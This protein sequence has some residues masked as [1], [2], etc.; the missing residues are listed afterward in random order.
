MQTLTRNAMVRRLAFAL[1]GQMLIS[2]AARAQNAPSQADAGASAWDIALGGGVA[3][4]PSYEGSD[5]YRVVPAPLVSVNWTWA[6]T[7]SLGSN[8]LNVYWHEDG[9]RL[10]TGLAYDSGRKD[11]AGNGIFRDGDDRLE[12]LGDIG[13]AAGVRIFS[14]YS[15]RGVTFS[16]AVTRFT[17]GNNGGL[18]VDAGVSA[19]YVLTERATITLRAGASWEDRTR[20]QQFFGVTPT[21]ALNSMF[22]Q[23]TAHAGVKDVA[24]GI[25]F[26]YRFSQHL[27]LVAGAGAKKLCGDAARSPITFAATGGTGEIML[28]YHF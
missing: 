20:M 27:F 3:V 11:S 25:T 23:F 24:A 9:F 6:D 18:Q 10:G 14:A 7:V 26:R 16:E 21:Q 2:L 4:K 12:G 17:G 5:R 28:G 8:G 15:L 19:P 13:A 1:A 22:P